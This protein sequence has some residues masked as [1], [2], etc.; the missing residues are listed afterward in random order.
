[1]LRPGAK[2][3]PHCSCWEKANLSSYSGR[4]SSANDLTVI[5]KALSVTSCTRRCNLEETRLRNTNPHFVEAVSSAID[6]SFNSWDCFHPRM[7]L[8]VFCMSLIN[9]SKAQHY[10]MCMMKAVEILSSSHPTSLSV[11]GNVSKMARSMAVLQRSYAKVR[12]S[13]QSCPLPFPQQ[14]W[15]HEQL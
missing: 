12:N 7:E 15:Y 4:W 9:R 6:T 10:L 1:M 5:Y 8:L 3:I 13:Y 11:H 2:S 14:V